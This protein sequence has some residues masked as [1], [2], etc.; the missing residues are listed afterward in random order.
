MID[1]NEKLK[2][3][4]I[5]SDRYDISLKDRL[6]SELIQIKT[7]ELAA[8]YL[9]MQDKEMKVET[10]THYTAYLL[11]L[12]DNFDNKK[13]VPMMGDMPDIDVDFSEREPVV[14]YLKEKYGEDNVAYISNNVTLSGVSA[15]ND[16]Q[17]VTEVFVPKKIK[18][19]V[20]ANK[21]SVV[22]FLETNPKGIPEDIMG[23]LQ[24]AANLEG[25]IRQMSVT[26]AG[27]L[28]SKE[29]ITDYAALYNKG[30]NPPVAVVYDKDDVERIG[31][32]KMDVLVTTNIAA[33][34]LTMKL[35]EERGG[36]YPDNIWELPMNDKKVIKEFAKGNTDLIFQYGGH[37]TQA[38]CKRMKP[39]HY[40][41]IVAINALSRPGA[42]DKSYIARKNGKEKFN[43]YHP[44]LKDILESTY[45]L[46]VYQEQV[47]A[48]CRKLAGM[49]HR[50]V[51]R[52]RKMVGK[53]TYKEEPEL[54]KLFVMGCLKRG[55]EP[56]RSNAIWA[57]IKKHGE[58]SFNRAHCVAYFMQAWANMYFQVHHPFE[59]FL[60]NLI[61]QK[62]DQK[63][64]KIVNAAQKAGIK[65]GD[66]D[67][68]KSKSDW[69][70]DGDT[71]IPGLSSIKGLG[72]KTG[73]KIAAEAAISPFVGWNT[74]V[75]NK[76]QDIRRYYLLQENAKDKDAI[77]RKF[78]SEGW[79]MI[80]KNAFDVLSEA[81][82]IPEI[83][84]D[85]IHSNL[86]S[87]KA[88]NVIEG[89]EIHRWWNPLALGKKQDG[90]CIV[91]GYVKNFQKRG[92]SYEINIQSDISGSLWY[93]DK[94]EPGPY[95]FVI[96]GKWGRIYLAIPEEKWARHPMDPYEKNALMATKGP[97]IAYY[98]S[99][100]KTP[101]G[102][103]VNII[104]CP[105]PRVIWLDK[106]LPE[107]WYVFKYNK[108]MRSWQFRPLKKAS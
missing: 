65:I 101:N 21:K 105:Q 107:N 78:P 63:I 69:S 71:L 3:V 73:N 12:S 52:V 91:H 26:A 56:E 55:V 89:R 1:F 99:G 7:Q 41:D 50:D 76:K 66:V 64:S 83:T 97:G 75:V 72:V 28:V 9:A 95:L 106:P 45:G 34:E 13:S 54:K 67:V 4:C 108:E 59:W 82:A 25:N 38:L 47:M 70:Y 31:F 15:I 94:L 87:G 11:Y 80:P 29:P 22:R 96:D 46:M 81:G 102:K 20:E 85:D 27:V 74:T 49:S 30:G 51:N 92:G 88:V 53:K 23:V 86:A 8:Y 93:H 2:N 43:Y 60:A 6:E 84:G 19:A 36:K 103:Y 57:D 68:N 17:R 58:Y 37:S 61:L 5:E 48:I 14:E 62:D 18:D 79:V 77:D 42:D 104:L 40:E 39:D 35:I 44:M 98:T 33:M 24:T 100:T 32:T 10:D 16:V 90:P